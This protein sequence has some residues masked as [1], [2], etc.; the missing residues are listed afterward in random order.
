MGLE[1]SAAPC[2]PLRLGHLGASWGI[3]GH[4]AERAAGTEARFQPHQGHRRAADRAGGPA[5][6][7]ARPTPEGPAALETRPQETTSLCDWKP[8]FRA[9]HRHRG[10]PARSSEDCACFCV[11]WSPGS[12]CAPS[13][14][15]C[16]WPSGQ[17]GG[18]G[19]CPQ[20][21]CSGR[22]SLFFLIALGASLVTSFPCGDEAVVVTVRSVA[23]GGPAAAETLRGPRVVGALNIA[24]RH[25]SVDAAARR[26]PL[27]GYFWFGRK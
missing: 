25:G 8:V 10:P 2:G 13:H 3:S 15:P 24:T 4:L 17:R 7:G 1:G 6:K 12:G 14:R 16:Q 5:V 19:L 9:R 22:S 18:R 20:P 23:W 27:R 21:S 26:P 11:S